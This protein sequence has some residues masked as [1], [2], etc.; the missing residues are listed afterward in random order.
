MPG[1][2]ALSED[3]VPA[4]IDTTKASIARVYD[5]FLNGK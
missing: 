1:T 5:A 2:D 3:A 4:Y